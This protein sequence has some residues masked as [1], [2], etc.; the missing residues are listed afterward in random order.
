ML[1]N[2]PY[3]WDAKIPNPAA[4]YFFPLLMNASELYI[5]LDEKKYIEKKLL[6]VWQILT[7]FTRTF[8]Q[9][10]TSFF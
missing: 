10:K 3:F 4:T 1:Q 9:V 6:S 5:D 8:H 7:R 2:L